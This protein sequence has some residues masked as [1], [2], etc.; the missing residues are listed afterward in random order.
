MA[1]K[2]IESTFKS[3]RD[4]ARVTTRQDAVSLKNVPDGTELQYV[5]HVIQE[6]TNDITGEIFNSIMLMDSNGVVYATRSETFIRA[7]DDILDIVADE[8]P[9]ENGNVEP[10]ILR[11][12]HGTSRS[13]NKFATCSLV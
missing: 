12:T 10:V 13:G 6:I 11:I 5:G 1:A 9:D 4:T 8:E 7:L 3:K 2:L